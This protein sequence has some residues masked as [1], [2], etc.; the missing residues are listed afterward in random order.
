[1]LQGALPSLAGLLQPTNSPEIHVR[2]LLALGMLV[3]GNQEL[4]TQLSD[5][6]GAVSRLLVLR[7]Q[8]DDEDSKQIAEGII[9]AMVWLS[10]ILLLL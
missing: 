9:A 4:Q 1:M 6:E 8:Q 2:A 3:G 5:V 7:L 10:E